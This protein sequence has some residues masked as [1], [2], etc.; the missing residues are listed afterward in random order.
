MA[1]KSKIIKS[2]RPPKYKVQA[3]NRCYLTQVRP[4]PHMF[5]EAGSGRPDSRSEEIKLVIG[6]YR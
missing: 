3:R 6:L 2:A 1:K 5:P 4:V